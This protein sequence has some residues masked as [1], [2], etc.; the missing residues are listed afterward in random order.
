MR[1]GI[2]VPRSEIGPYYFQAYS[3]FSLF[4]FFFLSLALFPTYSPL[5]PSTTSHLFTTSFFSLSYHASRK[6]VLHHSLAE[7]N[8]TRA[9]WVLREEDPSA[10]EDLTRSQKPRNSPGLLLLKG[11]LT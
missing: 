9:R 5:Y 6:P 3:I 7:S 11:H 2:H 1:L 4:T 8:P 10:R